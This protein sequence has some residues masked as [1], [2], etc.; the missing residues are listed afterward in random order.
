MHTEDPIPGIDPE[1]LNQHGIF[2]HAEL[3]NVYYVC[4]D[5]VATRTNCASG[6]HF[7]IESRQCLWPEDAGRGDCQSRESEFRR[8]PS[9]P[10]EK[11][12]GRPHLPHLPHR[13]FGIFILVIFTGHS[14]RK[15]AIA[16]TIYLK[17]KA[18]SYVT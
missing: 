15:L 4:K 8:P 11:A 6:L 17:F 14:G 5:G 7:H 3:C 1:C 18:P 16:Y 12:A 10:E 13:S 2:P 9:R